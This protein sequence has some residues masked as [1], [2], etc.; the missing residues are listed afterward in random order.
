MKCKLSSTHF[1]DTC[2][3]IKPWSV[4]SSSTNVEDTCW[5]IDWIKT[6]SCVCDLSWKRLSI[7]PVVQRLK[8]LLRFQW[9]RRENLP[10]TANIPCIL[11]NRCIGCRHR[12]TTTLASLCPNMHL[13]PSQCKW[14]KVIRQ[15]PPTASFR[16]Y[17]SD[18]Y[19]TYLQQ[20]IIR[21][22]VNKANRLWLQCAETQCTCLR[23]KFATDWVGMWCTPSAHVCGSTAKIP[24]FQVTSRCMQHLH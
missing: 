3:R 6:T 4:N 2:W 9:P 23:R 13:L 22:I 8:N 14:M 7:N 1:Q 15:V 11:C 19:T 17:N 16:T 10:T 18:S 12:C 24:E 20:I 5:P 21:F